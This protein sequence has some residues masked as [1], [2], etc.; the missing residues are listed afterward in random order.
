M[1][2]SIELLGDVPTAGVALTP[3]R[4]DGALCVRVDGRLDAASAGA[5]ANALR[6]AIGAA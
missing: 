3:E 5:F 2:S 4:R 6:D 1:D